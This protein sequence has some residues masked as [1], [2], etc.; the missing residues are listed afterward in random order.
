MS[1]DKFIEINR[2]GWNTLIQ[3]NKPFSNTIL[4]EY[5]P[6]L[7]RNEE[8]ILLIGDVKNCRVLDLGCGKG[9]SLEYL[10]NKGAS[11]IWGLDVSTE[12]I[13]LAKRRFPSFRNNFVVSPMEYEADIPHNYFDCVISI[14]SIGYTSDLRNTFSNVF[15]YLNDNG[16]F[17]VS[18]T[19][20]FY[21]CL[22]MDNDKVILNKSYFN[23]DSEI[24]TK[25]PD[26][27]ELAQKNLM[28]ST[29]INT[30]I[31][32]GFYVD[33]MLEEETVLKDDVNGYK[34]TFWRKEKVVNCPSTLLFRLKK[35]VK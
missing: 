3:S 25:G 30:A 14:F 9:E 29:F 13:S 11:D 12:Q 34:S 21:Y 5:G 15:K 26:K 10:Y 23:E 7:K 32:C 31:E 18:W 22:D 19:H 17:I 20:P 24:I 2:N 16:S 28:I 27:V 8:D 6:F 1:D 35:L 4:P 33:K